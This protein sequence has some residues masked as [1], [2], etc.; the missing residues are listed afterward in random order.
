M[1][2][3]VCSVCGVYISVYVCGVCGVCVVSEHWLLLGSKVR[4]LGVL[5]EISVFPFCNL[6]LTTMS[7]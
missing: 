7:C 3:C 4:V 5:P 2:L 6:V 1:H